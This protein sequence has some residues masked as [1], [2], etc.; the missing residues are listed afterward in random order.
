MSNYEGN[1]KDNNN[2][3]DM[4][5]NEGLNARIMKDLA[6]RIPGGAG[7]IEEFICK[8][9]LKEVLAAWAKKY[10]KDGD[11]MAKIIDVNTNFTMDPAKLQELT[12][13]KNYVEKQRAG[14]ATKYK[15]KNG[16]DSVKDIF[17]AAAAGGGAGGAGGTGGKPGTGLPPPGKGG[18][19]TRKPTP[20]L[21][22]FR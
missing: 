19:G 2:P 3:D 20:E 8:D 14:N 16:C 6:E 18:G 1:W 13:A 15:G 17:S 7:K 10:P 5:A 12:G 11:A 9:S 21:D 4:W 22:P